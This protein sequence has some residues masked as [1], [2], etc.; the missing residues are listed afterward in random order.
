MSGTAFTVTETSGGI[1]RKATVQVGDDR[2]GGA[3]WL[4]RLPAK[5]REAERGSGSRAREKF[6]KKEETE[7]EA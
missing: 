4:E 2:R 3:T 5:E 6:G 1:W 7:E